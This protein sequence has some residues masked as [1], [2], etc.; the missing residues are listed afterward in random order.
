MEAVRLAHADLNDDAQGTAIVPILL[1][2]SPRQ[3]MVCSCSDIVESI[4]G[5]GVARG[6][7]PGKKKIGNAFRQAVE[8]TIQSYRVPPPVLCCLGDSN[9]TGADP[10]LLVNEAVLHLQDA[11]IEDSLTSLS[12]ENF[13]RW[14][15]EV[16]SL[17]HSEICTAE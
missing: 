15:T 12:K 13:D 16:A 3:I 10:G 8:E 7:T 4:D 6:N 1:L 5:S 17:L 2:D 11:L 14:C 9:S